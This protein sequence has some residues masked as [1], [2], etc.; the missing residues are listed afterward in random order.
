MTVVYVPSHGLGCR[1][2]VEGS[3]GSVSL[4]Y[5]VDSF[6]MIHQKPRLKL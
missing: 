1:C 6:D 3:D 2:F 5:V 4:T